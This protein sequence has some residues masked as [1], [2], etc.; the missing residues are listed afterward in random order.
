MLNGRSDLLSCF[1]QPPPHSSAWIASNYF[2]AFAGLDLRPLGR[3]RR[4]EFG[5]GLG[6]HFAFPFLRGTGFLPRGALT[7]SELVQ[8][9]FQSLHLFS[10]RN[11][12]VELQHRHFSQWICHLFGRFV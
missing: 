7:T 2:L 9:A 10:D 8:F 1:A 6:A 4:G 11:S 3:H 12:P 5:P